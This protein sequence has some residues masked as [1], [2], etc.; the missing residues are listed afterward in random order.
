M[1]IRILPALVAGFLVSGVASAETLMVDGQLSV[2]PASVETPGRGLNMATVESRF[3][4]PAGKHAPVGQP[5]ITR[6]D[7]PGFSVFFE[8]DL[9]IHSV[10]TTR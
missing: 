6:W 2:A 5:P 9:V 8:R 1:S 7:Y 3:G 10:V 4:A